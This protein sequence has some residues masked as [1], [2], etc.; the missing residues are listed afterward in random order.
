MAGW[1]AIS[2]ATATFTK[3]MILEKVIVKMDFPSN[4]IPSQRGLQF[5]HAVVFQNSFAENKKQTLYL[6]MSIIYTPTF[7]PSVAKR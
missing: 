1:L 4:G 2:I 5:D 6:G 7:M 3:D